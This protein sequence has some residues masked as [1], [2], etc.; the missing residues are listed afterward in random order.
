MFREPALQ[1]TH[2]YLPAEVRPF[3]RV[4]FG[5]ANYD[6]YIYVMTRQTR[7]GHKNPSQCPFKTVAAVPMDKLEDFL[8]KMHVSEF[9]D[10]YL[11]ANTFTSPKHRRI[12]QLFTLNNLVIDIDCHRDT[13]PIRREVHIE[14]LVNILMAE[15]FLDERIP[16]PNSIVYTGRGIQ[17]WWAVGTTH[18]KPN[19]KILSMRE[20][21]LKTWTKILRNVLEGRMEMK[22]FSVD[23]AASLNAAGLF[24]MPGSQNLHTDTT[25]KYQALSEIP[26]DFYE[27]FDRKYECTHT[28]KESVRNLMRSLTVMPAIPYSSDEQGLMEGID[29]PAAYRRVSA[30]IALRHLRDADPGNE[31]RDLMLFALYNAFL[32]AGLDTDDALGRCY[33][34]NA[35]FKKPLRENTVRNYLRASGRRGGYK[36]SND[37]L[38]TLLG[39]NDVEQQSIKLFA[40]DDWYG[41]VKTDTRKITRQEKKLTHI[42]HIVA[43]HCAG[44]NNSEIAREAKASRPT[45]IKYVQQYE[46]GTLNGQVHELVE[47]Y[48]A[49]WQAEKTEPKEVAKRDT[50]PIAMQRFARF[51]KRIVRNVLAPSAGCQKSDPINSLIIETGGGGGFGPSLSCAV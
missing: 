48:L 41:L 3:F 33:A 11:S 43:L 4:H 31:T 50:K 51:I 35:G 26:Y 32:F 8:S 13:S 46:D 28:T 12:E 29:K 34:F 5:D 42:A 9:G 38:I 37:R 19:G 47:Q 36:I 39:I 17:L 18:I 16:M 1:T 14:H 7:L 2:R 20:C 24:R 10:Y 21:L 30:I 25:V 45:V 40:S 44:M 6:G 23:E 27:L 49:R 22:H 15:V